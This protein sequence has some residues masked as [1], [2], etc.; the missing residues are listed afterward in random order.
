[1]FKRIFIIVLD[2]LGVGA[3]EDA[4][5]YGDSNTNTLKNLS[6]SKTDFNVPN[7]FKL[8]IGKITEVNNAPIDN[9]PSAAYGKLAEISAGKDTLTGHWELMGLKTKIPFA[10]F[11]ENGFPKELIDQIEKKSGFKTI[12]NFASSGTEIMEELGEEH[13][14]SKKPI[15]YTS[16]DSVLQIAA[17]EIHFGLDNLYKICEIS[18]QITLEN[19]DWKVGRVIARPFLG[20]K[21]GEFYRTSNRKDYAV[22]PPNPTVLDCLK[23]NNFDVISIG[24]INDIFNSQGITEKHK[25]K[26]NSDGM[27]ILSEIMNTDFNGLC[28][29]NLVDFDALYGHR[30]DA[31]GYAQALEKFDKELCQILNKLSTDDLLIITADHGNNPTHIGTD[32]TREYVPLLVYGKNIRNVNL[33]ERETFAD[34]GATISENF[35]LKSPNI[36]TSFLDKI[37]K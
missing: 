29:V 4:H 30:R 1:M 9:V 6:Y 31:Y 20:E 32:H 17:H 22:S 10:V 33:G 7:L 27:K 15:I 8:G 35:K 12:G 5:L 14:L 36:G 16:A 25:I 34:V 2:S 18:R 21:K 26:S 28:F 23:A 24:K 19:E 37:K 13:I 3:L 11:E